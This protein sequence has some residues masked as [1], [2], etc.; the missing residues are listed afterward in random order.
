MN[1]HRVPPVKRK[2]MPRSTNVHEPSPSAVDGGTHQSIARLDLLLS[3]LARDPRRGLRLS[4]V[5]E[6]SGLGRATTHRLLSGM[7]AYGLADL[8]AES[9]RYRVGF[10]VF[11]WGASVAHRYGLLT[12]ARP[13][14]QDLA[15][16]FQDA[17][18]LSVRSDN[19]VVCIERLVG[20]FPIKSLA[21]NVGD[22]RPLGIG[23]GAAA[24]LA[25]LPAPDRDKSLA[26][27]RHARKAFAISE[28]DVKG[29]VAAAA[30]NGY[31][32]VDGKIVPGICTV[33]V[34]ITTITGQPVGAISVSA[35]GE[36]MTK[37][38]RAQIAAELAS[39]AQAIGARL[40]TLASDT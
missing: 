20:D 39:D 13:Y 17:V 16:R 12:L 32:V 9:G 3:V 8:D 40:G 31:A 28:A 14:L 1:K 29:I 33:G 10:K 36:R 34:A 7:V 30:K 22:R 2:A 4:E 27:T 15:D 5:A 21:F 19:E 6:A 23:A 24:I 35:I 11:T 38:R 37:S 18:Y 25:A 26:D